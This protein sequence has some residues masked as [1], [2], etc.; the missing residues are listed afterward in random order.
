MMGKRK[1]FER[2]GKFFF[3]P[4]LLAG[5]VFFY[6]GANPGL[7]ELQHPRSQGESEKIVFDEN[8][9]A[10]PSKVYLSDE[11][12]KK[13]LQAVLD[14]DVILEAVVDEVFVTY[15][16]E[17]TGAP[18]IPVTHFALKDRVVM[19]GREL[20]ENKFRYDNIQMKDEDAQFGKYTRSFIFL[21][22][23]KAYFFFKEY[24]VTKILRAIPEYLSIIQ[25]GARESA[26]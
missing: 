23:K 10:A 12:R 5:A 24:V 20:K 4:L 16:G 19:K 26:R 17:N 14:A 13:I 22:E 8:V 11:E 25:E 3:F 7:A 9:P 2:Q 21:K 18:A 6:T 1:D 15:P